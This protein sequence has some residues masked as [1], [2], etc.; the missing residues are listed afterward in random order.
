MIKETNQ[1]IVKVY[2]KELIEYY[3]NGCSCCEPME[4]SSYALTGYD[5][6]S[7]NISDELHYKLMDSC[8]DTSEQFRCLVN[9]SYTFSNSS[10]EYYEYVDWCYNLFNYEQM[11]ELLSKDNIKV[12]FLE[13]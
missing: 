13:D 10:L 4:T 11:E 3:D 2:F 5:S 12:V 7:G 9:V 1:R 6:S 8:R